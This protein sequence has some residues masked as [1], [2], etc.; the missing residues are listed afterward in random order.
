MPGDPR[1]EGNMSQT[2]SPPDIAKE[3]DFKAVDRF[4]SGD[5]AAFEELMGRYEV[6]IYGFLQRMCGCGDRAKDMVQ[7]TFLT[8]YRYLEGFRGEASFKTWLYRIASTSCMKSKRRRKNEPGY[9]LSLDDLVPKDQEINELATSNWHSVPADELLTKELNDHIERSLMK[10][11][12]KYRITFVLRDMEGLS[13]EET[14]V[15]LK[16][17]VPAVKSRLHRARLFLR[18]ELS[19]YYLHGGAGK[20]TT[21]KRASKTRA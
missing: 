9:H 20:K 4:K 1:M 3:R 2:I 6:K 16:I 11:E 19:E 18:K 8:A 12:E 21:K 17:S 5:K 14:A 15:A 10:L 7:E 13:A